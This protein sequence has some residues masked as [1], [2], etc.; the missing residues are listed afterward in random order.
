M[1]SRTPLRRGLAALAAGAALACAATPALADTVPAPDP[2]TAGGVCLAAKADLQGSAR[3]LALSPSRRASL[4]RYASDLCA[5]ADALVASL[6]PAQ[7]ADLL[8]QFDDA[9]SR[10]VPQGW[11]TADQAAALQAAAATL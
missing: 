4:D 9:T 5:R 10:A 7:K 1:Q 2:P 11:L 3:Y 8:V 6:T